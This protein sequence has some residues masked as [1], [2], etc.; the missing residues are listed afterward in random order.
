M[1]SLKTDDIQ[2][3]VFGET[4]NQEADQHF[5]A[6]RENLGEKLVFHGFVSGAERERVYREA[7]ILVLP[8]YGE[9]LPMVI[10]EAF[11]AGCA[12]ISTD[13]GAI[14]EIVKKENGIIIHPGDKDAL[15]QAIQTLTG[16]SQLLKKIQECNITCARKYTC[17]KFIEN[18]SAVCRKG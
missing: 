1:N 5:T 8:S 16:D 9:G 7:D 12:V 3:H 18:L 10:M 2:L 14:P 13:V 17:E 15:K 6:L 11:S 4:D